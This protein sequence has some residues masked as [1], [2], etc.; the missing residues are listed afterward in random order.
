LSS[1][2]VVR[3]YFYVFTEIAVAFALRNLITT[4]VFRIAVRRCL[5]AADNATIDAFKNAP[6]NASYISW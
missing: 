1:F 2:A 3:S 6:R 5:D 4:W